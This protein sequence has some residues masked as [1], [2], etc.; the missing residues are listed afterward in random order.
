M[1]FRALSSAVLS[2]ALLCATLPTRAADLAVPPPPWAETVREEAILYDLRAAFDVVDP[3]DIPGL[4]RDD[5]RQFAAAGVDAAKQS[6]LRND[7]LAEGSYYIVSLA[8]LISGG[9]PNWPADKAGSVYATEAMAL[10]AT[11]REQW[12]DV[13]RR[14]EPEDGDAAQM[15]KILRQVD[16]VNAWTDGQTGVTPDLDHFADTELLAGQA[17]EAALDGTSN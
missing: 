12:L 3:V 1:R 10:L 5:A 6:R 11:L 14:G 15:L 16:Q 7:L 17:V 8:Y 9:G 13:T 2:V 4:L